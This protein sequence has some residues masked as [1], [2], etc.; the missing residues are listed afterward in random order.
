MARWTIEIRLGDR[1]DAQ[2]L[3]RLKV[4]A[5]DMAAALE[6]ALDHLQ[7]EGEQPTPLAASGQEEVFAQAEVD[8]GRIEH[9]VGE[10]GAESGP[11]TA[12]GAERDPPLAG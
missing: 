1:P 11:A 10:E 12:R 9:H 3:R 5:I 8:A 4:E 6:Q 7:A 2:A